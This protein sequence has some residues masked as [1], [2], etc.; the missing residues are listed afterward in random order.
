[1]NLMA[2]LHG[3]CGWQSG[4]YKPLSVL[5]ADRLS[6]SDNIV[7][8]VVDGL[9]KRWLE[10][11][12]SGGLL[13]SHLKHTMYSVFPSTT[14]AALTS[15]ATGLA[16]KQHAVTGWFMYLQETACVAAILPFKPRIG[17]STFSEMG[18]TMEDVLGLSSVYPH[19]NRKCFVVN[20]EGIVESEFSRLVNSGATRLPYKRL[21]DCFNQMTDIVR[22][23][24]EKQFVYAYWPEFDGLCHLYGV[25]SKKVSTHFE[26]IEAAIERFVESIKG[27]NTS[28][29]VTADHGLIDTGADRVIHLHDH[30]V[31]EDCLQMPFSGEPRAAYAYVHGKKFKQF[32][33]YV[34]SELSEYMDCFSSES[35]LDEGY[36]GLG[37]LNK[38][39]L[40]RIGD[41]V[42]LPKS[43]YV[44]KDKI[45]GEGE[46]SQIGVHGG[47]SPEEMEI[48]LVILN[49]N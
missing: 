39:L 30:P 22:A 31:L 41:Y 46:F 42:L 23:Q 7:L 40:Q 36:F 18:I 3:C 17:G 2:S 26:H 33:D 5:D 8:L 29:I 6:S 14:S 35:L 4:V 25:E 1:V 20:Q 19:L 47:L 9:G 37:E 32:E 11:Y 49:V 34:S 43:N 21:D 44:V 38:K 48:P 28:L 15:F 13:H 16:P 45:A 27:T 10:S 24:E 12:A